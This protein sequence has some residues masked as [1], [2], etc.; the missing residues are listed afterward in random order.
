MASDD[1][2]SGRLIIPFGPEAPI[3]DR[4]YHFVCARGREKTD[5]ISKF[6]DWVKDE[7]HGMGLAHVT[8]AV[9]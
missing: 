3:L 6:R 5:N 8:D 4:A 2:R 7:I 9:T 1:I